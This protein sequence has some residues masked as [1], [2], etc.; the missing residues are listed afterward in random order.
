MAKATGQQEAS[1]FGA[2][3]ETTAPA[4]E[5]EVA[6]RKVRGRSTAARFTNA[7]LWTVYSEHA[8][9][10][11]PIRLGGMQL[12]KGLQSHSNRRGATQFVNACHKITIQWLCTRGL[13]A[14]DS[15]CKAFAYV[16]TTLQDDQKVAKRLSGYD[17]DAEVACFSLG[18]LEATLTTEE[19]AALH[20]CQRHLF[21]QSSEFVGAATKCNVRD[22]L[23]NVCFATLLS[24]FET[25]KPSLHHPISTSPTSR[26]RMVQAIA[27]LIC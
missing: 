6:A 14:M 16:G 21:Q 19:Q 26:T 17:P 2:S 12:T 8:A 11:E 20:C 4:S 5:N 25:M 27:A 15:L 13:W 1:L 7:W 10:S 3:N 9:N 18:V 24:S 22:T 23:E